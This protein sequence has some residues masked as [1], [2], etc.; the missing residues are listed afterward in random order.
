MQAQ[1]WVFPKPPHEG[2]T[3]VRHDSEKTERMHKQLARKTYTSC[4]YHR[5]IT[6]MPLTF[7]TVELCCSVSQQPAITTKRCCP[8]RKVEIAIYRAGDCDD[9][10]VHFHRSPDASQYGHP[11]RAQ[12]WSIQVGFHKLTCKNSI[13]VKYQS[14]ES[15]STNIRSNKRTIGRTGEGLEDRRLWYNCSNVRKSQYRRTLTRAEAQK[16]V[17]NATQNKNNYTFYM[18]FACALVRRSKNKREHW[19]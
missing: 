18:W 5:F 17:T 16:M 6:I 10:K 7:G 12:S 19:T 1:R 11:H 15:S 3:E 2:N 9:L 4:E 13:S 8:S 14:S